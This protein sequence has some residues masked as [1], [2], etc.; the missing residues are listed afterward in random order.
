VTV[1]CGRSPVVCKQVF[2][3]GRKPDAIGIITI[4]FILGTVFTAAVQAMGA[5]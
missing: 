1:V 3:M 4:V 2:V 5:G